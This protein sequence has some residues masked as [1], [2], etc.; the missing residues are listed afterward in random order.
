MHPHIAVPLTISVIA[1]R[2]D[3]LRE[4]A[5]ADRAVFEAKIVGPK[6]K[7]RVLSPPW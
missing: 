2:D 3:I 4:L 1:G 7:E 5:K 6:Y